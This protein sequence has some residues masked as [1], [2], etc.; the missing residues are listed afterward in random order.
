[1]HDDICNRISFLGVLVLQSKGLLLVGIREVRQDIKLS[2]SIVDGDVAD[3]KVI[4]DFLLCR[5]PFR[6]G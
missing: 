2:P 3:C 6:D 1:M 5:D 4:H